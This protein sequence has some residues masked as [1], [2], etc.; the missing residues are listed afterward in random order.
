MP[1]VT[2]LRAAMRMRT[3]LSWAYK[4]G[5]DKLVAFVKDLLDA[6]GV[7]V[8]S[9]SP[10]VTGGNIFHRLSS[11]MATRGCLT[12]LEA[13]QVTHI[14]FST[15]GME[16]YERDQ[17][18]W[19]IF[20]QEVF[21]FISWYLV[22]FSRKN[23]L[24]VPRTLL[25]AL[26]CK[27]CTRLVHEER[28]SINY[29]P[30]TNTPVEGVEIQLE[31][32]G[33]VSKVNNQFIAM[34]LAREARSYEIHDVGDQHD[35]DSRP[36]VASSSSI[37]LSIF[38]SI[39]L[40]ALAVGLVLRLPYVIHWQRLALR[41]LEPPVV[42]HVFLTFADCLL[43]TGRVEE[44]CII[45]G[46][47][48]SH[49][50]TKNPLVLSQQ[51]F[52]GVI[53]FCSTT[54]STLLSKHSDFFD[55]EEVFPERIELFNRV[56]GK[57]LRIGV[58]LG[59]PEDRAEVTQTNL[60]RR[61]P[62]SYCVGFG[63]RVLGNPR[64]ASNSE[65]GHS[66]QSGVP[67]E[68]PLYH[69][70]K[71]L[72]KGSSA[73]SKY[74]NILA[75]SNFPIIDP[76]VVVALADGCAGTLA[77]LMH[78]FPTAKGVYNSLLDDLPLS[79]S[80]PCEYKPSG[81]VGCNLSLRIP[82]LRR[83]V[84]GSSDITQLVTQ[85]KIVNLVKDLGEVKE[86]LLT[87]DAESRET[88]DWELLL[89][90]TISIIEKLRLPTV[91]IIKLILPEQLVGEEGEIAI[92]RV[93]RSTNWC[94]AKPRTSWCCSKEIFVVFSTNNGPTLSGPQ[95][96]KYVKDQCEAYTKVTSIRSL[97]SLGLSPG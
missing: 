57:N 44:S 27:Y 12:S 13:N 91:S 71:G 68:W 16:Y 11:V 3:L 45:Y 32:P 19:T 88:Q 50:A 74:C 56:F 85:T 18:D 51:V 62:L 72:G 26:E 92:T 38:R 42:P 65:R 33:L 67:I 23:P 61:A 59:S 37:N 58:S 41:G 34:V 20:F 73:A 80:E 22:N 84:T 83:M 94:V 29:V 7:D 39:D 36:L 35:L 10:V 69:L 53:K 47:P 63:S 31:D 82:N 43:R 70:S 28:L 8:S 15:S 14:R 52:L 87:M 54:H 55:H 64:Y 76:T 89:S 46:F 60:I 21:L 90:S 9:V 40:R 81:L 25:A 77:L 66:T 96:I 17:K 5:D 78:I 79:V 49:E 95:N 86:I 97:L 2:V 4:A 24:S 6:K 93:L 1:S 75:S 48:V 30:N